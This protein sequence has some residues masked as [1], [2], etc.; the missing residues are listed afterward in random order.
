MIPRIGKLFSQ[1]SNGKK[2]FMSI[3]SLILVVGVLAFAVFET[4]KATVTVVIDGEETEIK[5]HAATVADVLM[6]HDWTI[7]EHD[8][9]EPSLETKITGNMTINWKQA[10][11]VYL[12]NNGV[13]HE[14]W[15]TADSVKEFINEKNITLNEHDKIIPSLDAEIQSDMTITYESAFQVRL[16]SDDEEREVWTTST[17]VADFLERESIALGELDRVEPA[18]DSLVAEEID[19]NVIRV[20]KV[21]DV[22]EESVAYATVTRRDNS[23]DSGKE[24]VVES[25]QEGRVEKHYE[26]ILENGE[27]VSRELVKSQTVSESKDRIVAVGTRPVAT[28]SRGSSPSSTSSAPSGKTITMTATAYTANC[29]GCSGITATGINLNNNRNKKVVAVDP[30]VIPLGTRVHVQGYG[31]AIAGDTGGAIRGNKIDIHVPTKAEAN[32]WG[33]KQVKVTILD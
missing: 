1:L 25:G 28:V 21:T 7:S 30:S 17:T 14:E 8:K 26:V 27:E 4:T 19:V 10:K 22:V 32:R 33:R 5:T 12:S 11:Q 16:N 2:V 29:T 20:E 31:E 18:K 3:F 13:D 6:E 24:K 23:L 9:F 15:T